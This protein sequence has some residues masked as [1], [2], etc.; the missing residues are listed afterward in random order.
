M[1]TLSIVEHE[2]LHPGF[3]ARVIVAMMN[4]FVFSGAAAPGAGIVFATLRIHAQ[5]EHKNNCFSDSTN[6]FRRFAKLIST[7]AVA[8]AGISEDSRTCR[9]S[10]C[11]FADSTSNA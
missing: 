3:V 1:I 5:F 9:F 7:R 10:Q 6:S 4:Q 11:S 8:A 2:D